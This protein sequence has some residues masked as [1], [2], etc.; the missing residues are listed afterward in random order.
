MKVKIS[1]NSHFRD[2]DWMTEELTEALIFNRRQEK[3]YHLGNPD[4]GVD[5]VSVQTM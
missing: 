4:R 5:F 1:K 2:L 3:F